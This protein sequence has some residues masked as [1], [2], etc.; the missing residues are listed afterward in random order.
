MTL[1]D[2][3]NEK[4]NQLGSR[5]ARID[6]DYVQFS[7]MVSNVLKFYRRS[8][9][10]SKL[11]TLDLQWSQVCHTVPYEYGMGLSD[12]LLDVDKLQWMGLDWLTCSGV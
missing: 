5:A 12:N 1:E 8:K 7:R 9:A 6:Q 10:L 4:E 11:A 3:K 2:T